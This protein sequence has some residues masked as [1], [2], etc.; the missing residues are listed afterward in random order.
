MFQGRLTCERFRELLLCHERPGLSSRSLVYAVDA[1][2][3]KAICMGKTSRFA[4]SSQSCAKGTGI[5]H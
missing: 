1:C 3:K 5:A 4:Y 2:V